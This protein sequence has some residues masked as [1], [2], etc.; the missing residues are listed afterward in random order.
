MVELLVAKVTVETRSILCGV[1]GNRRSVEAWIYRENTGL[2]S[3]FK[4]RPFH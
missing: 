4:S 1:E 3:G 2:N